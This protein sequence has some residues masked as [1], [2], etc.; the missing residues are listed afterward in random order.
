MGA[1]L[2]DLVLGDGEVLAQD[3][4]I[5]GGAH[6][7]QVGQ[8]AAEAAGLG[9]HGDGAGAAALV[10]AGQGGRLGDLGERAL[11]GARPL[12]LGDHPDP[13]GVGASAVQGRVGV[14]RRGGGGH[15]LGQARLGQGTAARLEVLTDAV[16]DLLEDGHADQ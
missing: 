1:G 11:G 14:T 12:H 3:R 5:D 2:V 7:V 4:Q 6:G 9:E 8:A 16:D 10:R 15:Q 13:R